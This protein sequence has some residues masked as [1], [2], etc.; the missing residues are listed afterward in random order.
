MLSQLN[1]VFVV[2]D[3]RQE[4]SRLADQ[5]DQC[6]PVLV[7]V[8]P[9]PVNEVLHTQCAQCVT[10]GANGIVVALLLKKFGG[11]G[12]AEGVLSNAGRGTGR[13]TALTWYF[14]TGRRQSDHLTCCLQI[15]VAT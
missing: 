13:F 6:C 7:I 1:A 14:R 11:N 3:D 12:H 15:L 9:L 2:V 8:V 4:Q 5:L 10:R